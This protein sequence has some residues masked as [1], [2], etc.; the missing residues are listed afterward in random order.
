MNPSVQEILKRFSDLPD[1]L[2]VPL[3]DVHV[4]GSF[5]N[6]PLHVAAVQGDMEA[7]RLLI[8]AGADLNSQGEHGYTP[9]HEAVEQGHFEVADLLIKSGSDP[10]KSNVDGETPFDIARLL[11]NQDPRIVTLLN[12]ALGRH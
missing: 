5:G 7:V 1:F 9:L 12:G 2:G 3:T 4:R 6:T 8:D 11:P 10:K